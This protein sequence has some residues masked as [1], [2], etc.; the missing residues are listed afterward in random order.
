[1]GLPLAFG[2][3]IIAGVFEFVPYLGAIVSAIPAVLLALTIGST[4]TWIVIFLYLVVHGIDGYIVLPLVER[5]AV[6]IPPGITI[7]AQIAMYYLA[8]L[9]GVLVADPLA[10]TIL[11]IL[12]R[13]YM[14]R[15]ETG[16]A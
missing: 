2:L 13:F 16:T 11:V 15:E 5:R 10:A 3:G 9:L 6:Y 1:V 8:G 12:Q 14:H 4:T 7:I